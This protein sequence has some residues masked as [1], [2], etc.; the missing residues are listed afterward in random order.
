MECVIIGFRVLWRELVGTLNSVL[1]VRKLG[2][3]TFKL[4]KLAG[5]KGSEKIISGKGKNINR[6]HLRGLKCG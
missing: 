6:S 2:E 3:V 5:Q 4:R 1:M